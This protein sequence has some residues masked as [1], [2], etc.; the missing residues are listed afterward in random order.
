METMTSPHPSADTASVEVHALRAYAEDL[1]ALHGVGALL[2]WDHQVMMPG[3]AAGWRARQVGVFSQIAH[4]RST[5]DELHA[6]IS[7]VE[8][9]DP[10]N[11]EAR[12]M[13]RSFRI[14]TQLP[15]DHVRR[16][17]EATSLAQDAWK[18]ARANND[19][20]EFA[21]HLKAVLD[22]K[23]ERAEL[24]G[25]ETEPYDA[26]HDLYEEGSRAVDLAR[27]FD[28]MRDPLHA[29]INQQPTPDTSILKRSYPVVEQ[30]RIGAHIVAMMG[31]ELDA[32][33]IDPTAHP[34]CSTI[35]QFDVRLTTRY[36]EHWLPGSL[37]STIHEAGH[38]IYEQ[39]LHR[40]A[41]PATLAH[42]AGMGMHES[43]SRMYENII[44]RGT[45]FWSYAYPSLQDAFPAALG[46]VTMEQFVA[47]LNVAE[48]S[49]IR[50]EADELTYN[51]HVAARFELE[52]A[53]INGTL[54]VDDVPEAW[55]DAYE[56]WV[57][58]RPDSDA[59]GCLQDV[60][61]SFGGFGYFPTYTLGNVYAAQFVAKLRE[62]IPDLDDRISSGDLMVVRDWFDQHVYRFGCGKTGS[63]FVADIT[64]GPVTAAPLIAYLT[65]RFGR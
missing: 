49:L 14:A 6:L 57:G 59:N 19:F 42:A 29:L 18:T 4:E 45:A 39:A 10:G 40:L 44:G 34:F 27:V 8:D 51:L 16:A 30:E 64:G 41:L 62:D 48:R 15:V 33:R 63:E 38:G 1:N 50:V 65:E 36:D 46:D 9:A 53:M 13:R 61:W 56:R 47:A 23:R 5:S 26:L 7:A 35:G 43:Q 12:V 24:I 37:H 3:R 55:N 20:S 22:I 32:G 21:P 54:Q 2:G 25:F 52:R 31:Y 58:I 11:V 60:H 28:E 17:S